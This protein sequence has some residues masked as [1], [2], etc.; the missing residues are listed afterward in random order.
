M[1]TNNINILVPKE[2][3]ICLIILEEHHTHTRL[4]SQA[5]A[6]LIISKPVALSTGLLG[7]PIMEGFVIGSNFPNLIF[8]AYISSVTISIALLTLAS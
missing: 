5:S 3:P 4:W 8:Y 7:K 6:N 2:T 1:L